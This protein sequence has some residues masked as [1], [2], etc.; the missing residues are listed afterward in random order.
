[1]K[2]LIQ[3]I[4]EIY[5]TCFTWNRIVQFVIAFFSQQSNESNSSLNLIFIHETCFSV[6]S[7]IF[8]TPHFFSSVPCK[9]YKEIWKNYYKSF[10]FKKNLYMKFK[11]YFVYLILVEVCNMNGFNN[12]VT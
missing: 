12:H 9:T 7:L 5:I 11:F 2:S 4:P 10:L 8:Y 1:M 3:R 6:Y